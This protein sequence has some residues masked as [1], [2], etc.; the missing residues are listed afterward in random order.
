MKGGYAGKLLRVNLTKGK[1]ENSE[2]PNEDILRKYI[3]GIGLGMRLLI[4]ESPEGVK[5]TDPE[6]PL[7]LMT[8]PL[9]GTSAP[10]SSNL[11]VV[12]FNFN[13][14]YAVA[15][16]H[17]HGYWAAYLKHAGY[18]GIVIT[19]KAEK[20]VYLWVDDD[21]VE[22]RDATK[23]WGQDTRETERLIKRELGDEE[24]ISVACI[25]PAGEA[26]LP[27]A[28][29]KNDRNHGA[30]K[31]SVGAVMGSKNLKAVAV[32]GS[33]I[34]E[35]NQALEFG[36]LTQNW[37]KAIWAERKPGEGAPAV[38]T[39][40]AKGGITRAYSYVGESHML[41]G[42]NLSDPL[43]GE[44]FSKRFV[45]AAEDFTI[46][47]KESYN[48]SISCAY[49]CKINSG[50]F[51]GFTASMC[52][53]GE[54]MEGA[55]GMVGIDDP[56]EALAL[57]DYF[58]GM[59]IDSSVGGALMGMA[60]ELYERG[61]LSKE[62]TGGLELNWGNY[63]AAVELLDQMCTGEGFG[64]EVLAKG[65]KEAAKLLGKEAEACVLHIRGGG[66]NMHDWRP[67]W[68]V[69]LGQIV[70]GAGVCWQGPGVDAWTTD[71]DLG[72]TEFGEP[73]VPEG[74]AE[75][76]AKTQMKKLWEDTLGVCWFALWGV[77]GGLDYASEAIALSTGWS[78][79]N[80]DEAML[81]GERMV[82]LQ[83]VIALKRGFKPEDE[84]DI[85]DR[86]LEAPSVGRAAGKSIK[87]HLRN[88]V[89]EYYEEM[90]WQTDTGRPTKETLKKVGLQL[91][92]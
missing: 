35:L 38:G 36:E 77:K 58:D 29:I 40:L 63:E 89:T 31:G 73:M 86:L 60:F 24:K 79:F 43:W 46:I 72:Y 26:M 69:L 34:V 61:I 27:G 37:D 18:D 15:T 70:A 11:A 16:G 68:S 78:D 8:G 82:N 25:G 53:G 55:A 52:G 62:D 30:S 54:N 21:K 51:A 17:T 22:I 12:S 56:S 47:P 75:A 10:S 9:T 87:P 6:A 71:P 80:R 28:S 74:K 32:R 13:T 85:S 3:G 14:P 66:I 59:G 41:A 1:F 2:L 4:D 90:G 44:D 7:L 81:V 49:D 88:M 5:A 64:G 84:F 45:K 39:I 33:G 67:A 76:V 48:C 65:L 20:P 83:R 57:T 92:L 50:K 19:G 42:K 91:D 23:V